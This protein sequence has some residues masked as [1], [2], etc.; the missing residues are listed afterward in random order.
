ML[1]F[2]PWLLGLLFVVA[3][4]NAQ[5]GGMSGAGSSASAGKAI[6]RDTSPLNPENS[7]EI[8][9]PPAPAEEKAYKAFRT[10]QS[11]S[12]EDLARKAQAGEDF[13]KKYP[14]TAYSSHVYSFLTVAYIQSG[15]LD[16]GLA[17]GEKDLQLNPQDYRTMAVLSQAI[18]RVFNSA[19]PAATSQL[20]KA[21]IYGKGALEG[22]TTL[23]KPDAMSDADFANLKNQILTMAHGGLGLVDIHKQDY[24]S[25]IPELEKAISFGSN[26]DPTNFYLLGLANQNSLHYEEALAAFEKCAAVRGHLQAVCAGAADQAKKSAA[27]QPPPK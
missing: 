2:A 1:K 16:K 4:V 15:A 24:A 17:A 10:F 7:L 8:I 23:R 6:G 5:S 12:N 18:S 9:K 25:A 13:L 3:G 22:A 11:M 20:A 19:A 14:A 27:Q 26:E 21:E